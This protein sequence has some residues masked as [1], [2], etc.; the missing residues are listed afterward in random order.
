MHALAVLA[1]LAHLALVNADVVLQG[2]TVIAFNDATNDLEIMRDTSVH[3]VGS[4]IAGLHP[5]SP[6]FTP[7]AGTEVLD[8]RGSIVSPGFFDMHRHAWQTAFKTLGSNTTLPEYALRY[9][10]GGPASRVFTPEDVE[11]GQLAGLYE[12]LNSG[13]TTVLDHAHHT[14][15]NDTTAAGLRG[16]IA[17]GLRVFWCPSVMSTSTGFDQMAVIREL[18]AGRSWEN[19]TTRIGLSFD[20]LQEPLT[21]RDTAVFDLA[22]E[23]DAPVMT[24]HF[25]GGPWGGD[26]LPQALNRL[27]FLNGSM[28]IVLSHG[29]FMTTTDMNLLRSTNQFLAITPESEMHYGHDHPSSHLIMDQAALG[30]DTHFTYST[31]IVG[32]ARIWLQSARLVAFRQ[33]LQK[34]QI[35]V[36]NPMSAKQAFF[37]ATRNGA[38]ALRRDDLGVVKVGAKADLVVFDGTSPNMLGW[39]D[40]VAAIILHSHVSD[41]Q[42]VL[43]DGEFRKRDGKIVFGDFKAVSERF[44]QS[45]DRIQELWANMNFPAF[46]S[47]PF[48]PNA[49]EGVVGPVLDVVR[50]DATGY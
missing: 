45:R 41:V 21:P 37:L 24:F 35:N 43:V 3:I 4:T 36:R 15:S 20:E 5:A 9:G 46:F 2:G 33:E 48:R 34:S 29:S 27:G 11:I 47:G 49:A 50:G 17:S 23:I 14:W 38:L 18:F 25:L 8:V 6:G 40:P 16:S 44:L 1:V 31:D 13:V 7:P 39:S 22:K 12:S 26:G 32:Q 30:V 19:S 28:P 42:H 10:S